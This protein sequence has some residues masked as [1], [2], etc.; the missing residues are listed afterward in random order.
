MRFLP[1]FL[2]LTEGV[3]GLVGA[4]PAAVNKLRLLR[5]A[6]ASVRW[7]SKDVVVA[8]E[9]MTAG[10]PS[11]PLEIS[12]ADPRQADFTDL[13]AV[14]SAAG[15][16]LDDDIAALA[17]RQHVAVNVVDRPELSTFIFPAIVDR[18][19]V[20]VAISTGGT[21]PV[22][23]RRLRE[24][25]EALLPA[26]IGDLAALMGR[27]R[28]HAAQARRGA[29]SLRRFWERVVDGPIG[30]AALAGR[31]RDAERALACAIEHSDETPAQTGTVF[32]VG[33]G[34]GAAD[35]L[36]LR[37][38]QALQGA[39]VVFYDE[40]VTAEIL[41]RA[42][43]DAERVFVGKRSGRPGIGQDAINQRLAEAARRGLNVVRL[44]G[45]DSFIFGRGGEALEYLRQAG[46]AVVVVPGVTAALGCAAEAGL[47]LSFRN[48]ATQVAFVT[49][50]HADA[51]AETDWSKFTDPKTTLVVYMGVG[52]A[53]LVRDG[54]VA[55]GRDANT[56]AAVL[57]RGTR[58]DSICLVG[59]L[60]DIPAL[61][62]RAGEGPGLLVIGQT[63]A[64]S[65][66]WQAAARHS[67]AR[68][69][70]AA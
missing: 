53:A 6:G 2:D 20:V 39:D 12:F 37:A 67:I 60:D 33:A 21:S 34:P 32:I 36:T 30:A 45:G 51:G 25:I 63:V 24:R 49:A 59:R 70:M 38:L 26:R 4:G 8:E 68:R 15:D 61:A 50:H 56:P 13:I 40:L 11:G 57:A 14:V 48:E 17:R 3:V 22:L 10:V 47:P 54:L 5:S 55:A 58:S 35:L 28:A 31:W 52:K 65:D 69:E 9:V 44:K 46:I 19:D 62:A 18:G 27:F 7:Y 23:A 43:R 29:R 64:R 42:R 16:A 66:A 41:D 1:V